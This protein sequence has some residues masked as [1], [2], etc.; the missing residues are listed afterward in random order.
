MSDAATARMAARAELDWE[1]MFLHYRNSSSDTWLGTAWRT[2]RY[3]PGGPPRAAWGPV[4]ARPSGTIPAPVRTRTGAWA[5]ARHDGPTMTLTDAFPP[6]RPRRPV[7]GVRDLG[8]RAR[9]GALP[10]SGRGAAR[11]RDRRERDPVHPDR[12]GQEPGRDRRAL[13]RAGR[14]P[15]HLLHR[16]DQGAGVGEVLRALRRSSAP[17]NVGMMTGDARVNADAPIICATAEILANIALREGAR[18]RR[19][20]GRDGRVPLLRRPRPRLGLA[21]AADRAA[22]GAV[23]ADVRDARRR[24]P[25]RGGPD[26]P[27]R[28]ADRGR[29]AAP[30]GPVPLHFSYAL[31]PLHETLEELLTTHQ[32]PVYVVHFTQAAALERAQALMSVNVCTPGREGRDRRGDRRLPVHRR[33]RQGAVP[34]GPPRHRRAPRRHA[35]RS[36]AGWSRRSPRP[37]CSRSSAVRTPSAS[38]STCRSGP[39]CSPRCRS[40]TASRTRLLQAREFHQ[41][42]G[43]AG[44]AGYDT[45]GYGRRPGPRARHRERAHARQGRR[46]REEAPEGGRKK[47][48]EGFVALG[49]ADVRAARSRPSRSRSSPASRSP[50]RCC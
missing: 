20:P 46:R 50:T 7:R 22:A 15:A 14:G 36:T 41:I 33:L 5:R 13:R 38:A 21:G 30:T 44:R 26:P 2:A 10:A 6:P 43:R 12:L 32:A 27:H 3:P 17:D 37:A 47:P 11:G 24:H 19:R 42:A 18:R 40:T 8:R 4:L 45:V 29:S 31:T 23:P 25:V 16:A 1:D 28:P 9:P 48:P 34:A 49:P 35:A 39:C